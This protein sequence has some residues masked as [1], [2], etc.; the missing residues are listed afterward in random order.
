M[1]E[2]G[3]YMKEKKKRTVLII[4]VLIISFLGIWKMVS[5]NKQ[6]EISEVELGGIYS[7]RNGAL[8]LETK[9]W[10]A[11]DN[12]VFLLDNLDTGQ[13]DRVNI[14]K[15]SADFLQAANDMAGKA[16]LIN[17]VSVSLLSDTD[18]KKVQMINDD[19]EEDF[20]KSEA[21]YWCFTIRTY[22]YDSIIMLC[23]AKTDE[24]IGYIE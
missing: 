9:Y 17:S 5:G 7:T 18:K 22:S 13:S 8:G 23:N 4:F 19:I 14:N 11:F 15:L 20:S 10:K 16:D 1:E 6:K 24:V 2:W 21:E 12:C 3:L